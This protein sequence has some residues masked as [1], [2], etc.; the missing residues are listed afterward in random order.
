MC[1]SFRPSALAS[2]GFAAAPA[3]A[4]PVADFYTGKTISL[5]IG[6]TQGGGYD[7]YA[8]TVARF[9]GK[10]MPGNPTI[11]P[12]QMPGAGS[13]A[14][15]NYLYNV[16]PKDGTALASADQALPV[17]EFVEDPAVRSHSDRFNW[18]GNAN[19]DVNIMLTWTPAASRQLMTPRLAK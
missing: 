5:Y 13:L 2:V 1:S 9:L 19:A 10:H 8:R 3:L 15:T 18:I 17:N 7:T 6:F 12:R 16:A 14:A 4:D 11:V